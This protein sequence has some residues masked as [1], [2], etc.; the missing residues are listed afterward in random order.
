[1]ESNQLADLTLDTVAPLTLDTVAPCTDYQHE[2]FLYEGADDFLR[3]T[4]EFILDAVAAAEPVLVVVDSDKITSLRS[5]LG[6]TGGDVLFADMAEVGTNPARII[7]AW[8]DFLDEHAAPHRRVRGIGEPIWAGRSPAELAECQRHEALLNLAFA[9]PSFWLLCPYD[10]LALDAPVI[11]EAI[12]THPIVRQRGVGRPSSSYPG[13]DAFATLDTSPLS[14][15]PDRAP[16]LAYGPGDVGQVRRFVSGH[17][18]RAG[19]R[20]DR[21]ADLVL[22]ADEMST[23]SLRHGGGLG[24]VGVWREGDEVICEIR[25]RGRILEPLAG[26]RRPP[27]DGDDGRGL[28]LANQ[29]CD[30]VQIRATE[31]GGVVRLR[32]RTGATR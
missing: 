23:N 22:A 13:R 11:D 2:A 8:Q 27:L 6:A 29:L 15:V 4:L 25:D 21:V 9:D 28:W 17:A 31:T 19:L 26:R 3:G 7:P 18:V 12:R 30:L 1:M 20:A 24:T 10:V 5:E 32:I 16:V 14:D